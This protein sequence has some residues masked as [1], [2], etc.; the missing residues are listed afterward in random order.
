MP[1]FDAISWYGDWICLLQSTDR[2][3]APRSFLF[4]PKGVAG[5]KLLAEGQSGITGVYTALILDKITKNNKGIKNYW[6][7]EG[8][9][10]L[11]LF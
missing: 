7:G 2:I 10:A 1:N 9:I 11:R 8:A 3:I 4:F 5:V 6:G